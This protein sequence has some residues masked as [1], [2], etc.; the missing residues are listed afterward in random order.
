ML[1]TALTALAADDRFQVGGYAPDY[2]LNAL[3]IQSLAPNLTTLILFSI[4]PEQHGGGKLD[5][6]RLSTMHLLRA[7]RAKRANPHL[8]ALV[9]VGGGGRSD[10]FAEACSSSKTRQRFA[11]GLAKYVKRGKLDGAD[12]DWEAPATP[13]QAADYAE[14]LKATRAAFDHI[15]QGA[16]A[17]KLTLSFALHPQHAE[18]LAPAFDHVHRVHLMAYDEPG[19]RG[20]STFAAAQAAVGRVLAAGCP[21]EKL[22]LG[23]PLYGRSVERPQLAETY[24][25]LLRLRRREGGTP[26]VAAA[27]DDD[28]ADADGEGDR[29]GEY[30]F[31]GRATMRHKVAFAISEGLAGVFAWEVGQDAQGDAEALLPAIAAQAHDAVAHGWR[32][33]Q[34]P[35]HEEL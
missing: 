17:Q 30:V 10:G 22:L 4:E 14:C 35:G 33:G 16:D 21:R 29:V 9:A 5:T 20:H 31:N 12:L 28:D 3:D 2:R 6:H 18:L 15:G 11:T 1:S 7:A 13:Q 25:A 19:P 32:L 34:G 23:V 27:G 26:A 8:T 24:S